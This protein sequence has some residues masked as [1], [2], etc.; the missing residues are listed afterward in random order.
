MEGFIF[1]MLTARDQWGIFLTC[2]G[3]SGAA[4]T[5]EPRQVREEAAVR[6]LFWVPPG[7]LPGILLP[8]QSTR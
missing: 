2:P 4:E 5:N 7:Y 6:R 3:G 8:F 1:L